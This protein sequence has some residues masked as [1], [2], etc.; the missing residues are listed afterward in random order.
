[1]YKLNKQ[2][3]ILLK[4]PFGKV[5]VNIPPISRS[6]YIVAVGD[7]TTK[8]LLKNNII[9]NLSIID[10]KTKRT[11][12]VKIEHKFSNVYKVN[13]PKGNI[14]T[15]AENI[16]KEL[17]L[18]DIYNTVLIVENGEEDLLALMVI[19]YFPVGSI[20]VY[21]QPNEGMVMLE[22]TEELKNKINNILNLMDKL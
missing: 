15:D 3:E 21:G 6:D 8:N 11:I 1:M 9:P 19:K 5:Y 7:I 22:I 14:T 18:K 12:P 17:S 4:K 2:S 16:I 13:N 20:V 10:Y